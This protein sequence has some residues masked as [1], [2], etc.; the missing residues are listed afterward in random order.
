MTVW[1][2]E[3]EATSAAS[4]V[5]CHVVGRE[6]SAAIGKTL[7]PDPRKDPV[8]L[9]VAYLEGIVL[10]IE[11]RARVE[12]QHQRLIHPNRRKVRGRS[13]V[14]QT[15]EV[16]ALSVGL[17]SYCVRKELPERIAIRRVE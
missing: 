14:G 13:L 11:G 2:L 5:D 12:V 9:P 16:G 3:V 17:A 1:I 7:A 6:R 4:M 10:P 15:K 8:E